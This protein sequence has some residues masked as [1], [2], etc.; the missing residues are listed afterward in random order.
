M[1]S[2]CT[3][4]SYQQQSLSSVTTVKSSGAVKSLE[5]HIRSS[6]HVYS[7]G[8]PSASLQTLIP[9]ACLFSSFSAFRGDRF[10]WVLLYL[11]Q[12]LKRAIIL[13]FFMVQDLHTLG[14]IYYIHRAWNHG[15][16]SELASVDD[17]TQVDPN[18]AWRILNRVGRSFLFVAVCPSTVMWHFIYLG[19]WK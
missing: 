18:V 19:N 15:C 3:I 10:E 16:Q 5:V 7:P 1:F 4:L 6:R 13:Q 2:Q 17:E 11:A 9:T 12:I 8:S 14:M